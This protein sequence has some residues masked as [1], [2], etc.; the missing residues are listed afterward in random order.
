MS[1]QTL[2]SWK[3]HTHLS[4]TF[5]TL[6]IQLDFWNRI[7]RPGN[8][9]ILYFM[10]WV[11]HDRKP[12]G[13]CDRMEH[14]AKPTVCWIISLFFSFFFPLLLLACLIFASRWNYKMLT[15]N[16]KILQSI[17]LIQKIIKILQ[18]L[19]YAILFFHLMCN[20]NANWK[21]VIHV[22]EFPRKLKVGKIKQQFMKK[23]FK[24]STHVF[25]CGLFLAINIP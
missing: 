13:Q 7:K 1:A 18:I 3:M 12:W 11:I 17:R 6:E 23:I 4:G 22:K 16:W 21:Q 19:D 25:S 10:R 20:N 15:T 8:A 5:L 9:D 24:F 14:A 2:L